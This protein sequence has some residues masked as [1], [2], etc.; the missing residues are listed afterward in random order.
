M[1]NRLGQ[2]YRALL[3]D[4]DGT[5][6]DTSP[7]VISAMRLTLQELGLPNESDEVIRQF[8]GPPAGAFFRSTYGFSEEQAR[9]AS[10]VFRHFFEQGDF[11]N[12]V[13]YPCMTALLEALKRKG[14]LLAVATNKHLNQTLAMLRYFSFSQFFDAVAG[15]DDSFQLTKADIIRQALAQLRVSPEQA[16]LIGDSRYDA[17]GAQAAG[18]DFLAV[19]YGLGFSDRTEAQVY[20][21]RGCS[22]SVSEL[23]EFL[24]CPL[25]RS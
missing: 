18:V 5:L 13:P 19:T 21:L 4:F 12:A 2:P 10:E 1:K 17:L 20:P 23:A 9:R 8:I 25:P 11:L 14:F 15:A 7:G 6:M 3:F 16:L 24:E 22:G